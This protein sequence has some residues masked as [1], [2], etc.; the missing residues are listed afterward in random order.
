MTEDPLSPCRVLQSLLRPV[1]PFDAELGVPLVRAG[2]FL[3]E[4]ARE[5]VSFA[6]CQ[7]LTHSAMKRIV[8]AH[9]DE[10]RLSSFGTKKRLKEDLAEVISGLFSTEFGEFFVKEYTK[11]IAALDGQAPEAKAVA[12]L[13]HVDRR[14]LGPLL[15]VSRRVADDTQTQRT[16]LRA[17]SRMHMPFSEMVGYILKAPVGPTPKI[18]PLS[19]ALGDSGNIEIATALLSDVSPDDSAR[20]YLLGQ[21]LGMAAV[22]NPDIMRIMIQRNDE[23]PRELLYEWQDGIDYRRR[24]LREEEG[25]RLSSEVLRVVQEASENERTAEFARQIFAALDVRPDDLSR[26]QFA[27]LTTPAAFS[28]SRP[29][30]PKDALVARGS[31]EV[32][33][34]SILQTLRLAE[35]LYTSLQ[36]VI[37]LLL[38]LR[39]WMLDKDLHTASLVL[40]SGIADTQYWD[41]RL[42][43]IQLPEQALDQFEQRIR[44]HRCDHSQAKVRALDENRAEAVWFHSTEIERA[45]RVL[46]LTRQYANTGKPPLYLAWEFFRFADSFWSEAVDEFAGLSTQ[47]LALDEPGAQVSACRHLVGQFREFLEAE[48]ERLERH[49]SSSGLRDAAIL[50]EAA[51]TP[52][53][54]TE[55]LRYVQMAYSALANWPDADMVGSLMAAAQAPTESDGFPLQYSARLKAIQS[56]A[57]LAETAP[58]LIPRVRPLLVSLL[59]EISTCDSSAGTNHRVAASLFLSLGKLG[60]DHQSAQRIV[61]SCGGLIPLWVKKYKVPLA[62]I[63]TVDSEATQLIGDLLPL[64]IQQLIDTALDSRDVSKQVMAIETLGQASDIGA[65]GVIALMKLTHTRDSLVSYKAAKS[66]YGQITKSKNSFSSFQLEA[67][68]CGLKT[69]ILSRSP[70]NPSAVVR[71]EAYAYAF[72][73]LWEINEQLK[74]NRYF[75]R[76]HT[77]SWS[78]FRVAPVLELIGGW[79]GLLGL[80]RIVA[81]QL[82]SGGILLT[83][84]IALDA[85]CCLWVSAVFRNRWFLCVAPF[86]ALVWL[87]GPLISALHLKKAIYLEK[88][89]IEPLR[90]P[91]H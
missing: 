2:R 17:I 57:E 76:K 47:L 23:L 22:K 41:T 35:T 65:N 73:A 34:E 53:L 6:E 25:P 3:L 74:E 49:I 27:E 7:D 64:S 19:E 63:R 5:G 28:L 8:K 81:G 36:S 52:D 55:V 33:V 40:E 61:D 39:T 9:L 86:I 44:R 26:E 67:I 82:A 31:L 4:A 29:T 32:S 12:D 84:W 60:I 78:R 46:R 89:C 71:S 15:E 18:G 43:S 77:Q 13:P 45:D 68:G 59:E 38:S 37:A 56:L 75:S 87:V 70:F 20:L 69:M 1:G 85:I 30:L 16:V 48:A 80:G 24:K 88:K 58:A 83:S 62:E 51:T 50:L 72:D 66:L 42:D 54:R 11:T 14:L 21:A 79:L 90:G 91:S 10:H